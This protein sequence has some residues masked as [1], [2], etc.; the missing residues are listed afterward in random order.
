MPAELS[1]EDTDISIL[2]G[3]LL[4]NAY[5]AC[6]ECQTDHPFIKIWG[7]Y[8]ESGF[9]V[10]FEN[11]FSNPLKEKNGIFHSTKHD[12]PGIGTES[13]KKVVQQYHGTVEFTK[14]GH[15]FQVSIILP[16]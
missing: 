3:N 12:G 11:T 9:L 15:I 10:R 6:R 8:R 14:E 1:M 16:I 5:E 7:T 2:F 4:E 13:V